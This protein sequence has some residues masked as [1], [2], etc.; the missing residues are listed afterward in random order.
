M[1][2]RSPNL[3]DERQSVLLIIDVQEK[4]IPVIHDHQ[5]IVWNASRLLQ[6]ASTLDIPVAVTEQYPQGLGQ[7]VEPFQDP[8]LT[9]F[10]KTTFS[11]Q[12]A[13]GLGAWLAETKRKQLIVAGVEAHVCVLQSMLDFANESW[14]VFGVQDAMGS[15]RP[16]DKSVAI[17]RARQSGVN[18]VTTESVLFEWCV[19]AKAEAFKTIRQLVKNTAPTE[20]QNVIGFSK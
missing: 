5:R 14:Q 3:I 18:L 11:A 16:E 13:E 10:E 15:R 9:R 17:E 2:N 4:L 19:D 7:S 8:Q 1:T 6:A 12:G 20:S